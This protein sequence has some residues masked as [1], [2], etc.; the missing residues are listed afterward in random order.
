MSQT[1]N[2]IKCAQSVDLESA[3]KI[4]L[5]SVINNIINQN[6]D[7][8]CKKLLKLSLELKHDCWIEKYANML[9][10]KQFKKTEH[11]FDKKIQRIFEKVS[12]LPQK[13]DQVIIDFTL[14]VTKYNIKTKQLYDL[15]GQ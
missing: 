12:N 2:L 11:E 13:Y 10:M 7:K 1:L 9:D 14:V 3:Y 15:Y 5:W 8:S 6:S 4:C